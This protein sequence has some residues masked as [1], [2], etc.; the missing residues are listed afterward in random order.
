V[1][2]PSDLLPPAV[3]LGPSRPMPFAVVVSFTYVGYCQRFVVAGSVAHPMME[4]VGVVVRRFGWP[5]PQ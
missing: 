5:C 3:S 1:G 2:I 4:I